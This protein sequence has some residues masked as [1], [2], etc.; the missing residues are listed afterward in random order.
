MAGQTV[1]VVDDEEGMRE[2][3]KEVLL[4]AGLE[5]D[6]ATSALDFLERVRKGALRPKDIG[7]VLLDVMMPGMSGIDLCHHIR[8]APELK[9]IKVAFLTVVQ[10][11]KFSISENIKKL[12]ALDY[13]QK[14]YGNE[15]LVERVK[16]ILSS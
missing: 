11:S 5:V 3:T 4:N 2:L 14:P 9:G 6:T 12:G 1:V 8:G 16:R 13:I 15:D 7:L 10:Y